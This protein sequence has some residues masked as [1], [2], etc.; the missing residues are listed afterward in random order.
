MP[1]E[2]FLRCPRGRHISIQ[3]SA[4]VDLVVG[5]YRTLAQYYNGSNYLFNA[6]ALPL[7]DV[8]SP[9]RNVEKSLIHDDLRQFHVIGDVH[10]AIVV[11]VAE[12]AA[13]F[14]IRKGELTSGGV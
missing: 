2:R 11:Q 5:I 10:L 12:F 3:G 14:G 4:H 6:Y 7:Y 13:R 8:L 9:K 1:R